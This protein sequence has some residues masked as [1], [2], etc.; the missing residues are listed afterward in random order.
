MYIYIT[1]AICFYST[2]EEKGSDCIETFKKMQECF[3]KH[4]DLYKDYEDEEDVV[5]SEDREM[6]E[7]VVD[8]GEETGLQNKE[9][10]DTNISEE[11]ISSTGS[12]QLISSSVS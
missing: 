12:K 5:G 8:S 4:P 1:F 7:V 3:Q 6:G 2:A 11:S 9:I 10:G